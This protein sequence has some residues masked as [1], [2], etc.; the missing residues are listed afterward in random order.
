MG[1]DLPITAQ[2]RKNP[3]KRFLKNQVVFNQKDMQG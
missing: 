1:M 2:T 3:T